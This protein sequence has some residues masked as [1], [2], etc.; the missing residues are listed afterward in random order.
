V[1]AIPMVPDRLSYTE[2]ALEEFKYPSEWTTEFDA[3]DHH[4]ELVK[5]RIVDYVE[6]YNDYSDL[7]KKQAGNLSIDYFSG[8]NMYGKIRV[9]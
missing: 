7:V 5:S 6:N 8:N 4:K 3:Y 1:D 9:G 2:M